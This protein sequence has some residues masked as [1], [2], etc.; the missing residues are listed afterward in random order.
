VDTWR[1]SKCAEVTH[2]RTKSG[3]RGQRGEDKEAR[4]KRE[5]TKREDKEGHRRTKRDKEGHPNI[6]GQRGTP[7]HLLDKQLNMRILMARR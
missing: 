2:L 3:Q 6:G 7:K 5:R 4:T 1:S